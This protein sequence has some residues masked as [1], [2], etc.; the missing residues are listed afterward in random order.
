MRPAEM[1]A[2]KEGPPNR[3]LPRVRL[4][5]V[6]ANVLGRTNARKGGKSDHAYVPVG[7]QG[8]SVLCSGVQTSCGLKCPVSAFA[9]RDFSPIAAVVSAPST[10][11]VATLRDESGLIRCS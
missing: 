7:R 9:D 3:P 6:R 11:L 4:R 1:R 5:Q 2:R 10:R 8:R